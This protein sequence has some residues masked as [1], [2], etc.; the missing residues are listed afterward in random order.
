MA[1]EYGSRH[2]KETGGEIVVSNRFV[3]WWD[4]FWYHYKWTVIVI[5]FFL[6]VFIVCFAQCSQRTLSDTYVTFSGG[7]VLSEEESTAISQV[8]GGLTK[9]E[10]ESAQSV[11]LRSYAFFSEEELRTLYTDPETGNFDNAGYNRAKQ[12]NVD[13]F[14]SLQDYMMTGECSIWFLSPT[15]YAELDIKNDIGVALETTFGNRPASAYDD[16][17]I[18]LGDTE[19]Y[20]YYEALQVLPEDTLVVLSASFVFGASA[21][22]GQYARVKELYRAIVEFKAPN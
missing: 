11:G 20:R 8:F 1:Q 18:R 6:L 7:V 21:D 4:N 3:K 2:D 13:R 22:E 12:A 17:A 19:L 16:Y 15:V 10:E 9:T 14:S 5:A